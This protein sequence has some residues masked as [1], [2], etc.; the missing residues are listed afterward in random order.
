MILLEP[1]PASSLQRLLTGAR[2]RRDRVRFTS[3]ARR[4]NRQPG[5]DL[6]PAG[7]RP[8]VLEQSWHHLQRRE[9]G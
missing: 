9:V 8:L 4:G 7:R 6:S 5:C 3:P 2:E 1:L